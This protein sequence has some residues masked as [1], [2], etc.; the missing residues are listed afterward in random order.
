MGYAEAQYRRMRANKPLHSRGGIYDDKFG[1]HLLRLL[2]TARCLVATALM[3][4]LK[5]PSDIR[6]YLMKVRQG[7]ISQN[8][9][10][11]NAEKLINEIRLKESEEK[12]PAEPDTAAINA[13]LWKV[14]GLV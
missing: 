9:V 4:P 6:N 2:Y 12:L 5:L 7:T 3:P 10:A 14:R 11:D 8:E 1:M 13:W